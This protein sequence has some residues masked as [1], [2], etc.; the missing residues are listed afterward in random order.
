MKIVNMKK[1]LRSVLIIIGLAVTI[2]LISSNITLSH[3]ESSQKTISISSGDT[4]WTIAEYEQ[5][6]NEYYKDSDI[7]DII[8]NI[9]KLNNLNTNESLQVGQKI[10]LNEI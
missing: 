7:R 1:F 6:N 3:T 10:I 8:Y 2:C 9:K 4:L 5:E